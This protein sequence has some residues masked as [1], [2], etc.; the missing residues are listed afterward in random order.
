[1]E[2]SKVISVKLKL[3]TGF[4]KSAITKFCFETYWDITEN[5]AFTT[6]NLNIKG[7]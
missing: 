3:S 6:H 7:G 1:M 4:N 5:I 2:F